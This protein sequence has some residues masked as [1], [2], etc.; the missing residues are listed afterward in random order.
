MRAAA[1]VVDVVCLDAGVWVKALVAEEG[2][3]L[4]I[5]LLTEAAAGSRIVAPAFCWAEVGSVLRKKERSGQITNVESVEAW[6]DF[7]A[8]R[9]EYLD[10]ALVR[11]RAWSL[12]AQFRQPTLYDTA[13]LACTE[14]ADTS[15]RAF[16]TADDVLLA[17]L[18]DDR[19]P[20]VRHLREWAAGG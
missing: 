2:S 11:D 16:W 4:A 3:E 10:G 5:Q 1:A 9:V 7:Q 13:Y 18:G 20:Y 15:S 19:P 8:M 6:A 12:A 14:S 17:A